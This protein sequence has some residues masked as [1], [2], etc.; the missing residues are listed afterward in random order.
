MCF[1]VWGP[2]VGV[3]DVLLVILVLVLPLII[4]RKNAKFSIADH[5]DAAGLGKP[6]KS[7]FF[8]GP[9]TKT[10]GGVRARPLRILFFFYFYIFIYFS[11]KIV[12]KFF[13][14]KILFRLF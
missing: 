10:G 12:E 1:K 6:Q 13:F 14:V 11:P 9:T 8:S 2:E 5:D 7:S 4:G 3:V